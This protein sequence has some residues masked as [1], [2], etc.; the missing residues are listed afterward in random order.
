M[1]HN[2]KL[3][4]YFIILFI[5][6]FVLDGHAQ[7][8][9][10]PVLKSNL[11]IDE[12]KGTI[13][14]FP[15]FDLK[16]PEAKWEEDASYNAVFFKDE[17]VEGYY[18]IEAVDTEDNH[19]YRSWFP[20]AFSTLS[21]KGNRSYV[22]S[23]LMDA[24]FE[25]PDEVN[26]GLYT[27]DNAGNRI[28][29]HLNGI[30]NKTNGWKRWEWEII[31]DP[32]ATSARFEIRLENF[33][34]KN[35]LKISDIALVELPPKAIVPFEKGKGATFK[36]GPGNLPMKVASVNVE[37]GFIDVYIT[38]AQYTFDLKNNT[39]SGRQLV[40]T[41]R[42]VC[43]WKSTADLTGLKVLVENKK[44]CVLA[45]DYI[46]FGIQCDG[47]LMVVPHKEVRLDVESKIGGKWNRLSSGH[48]LAR[49][50]I[51][52]FAVNPDIPRGS[53]RFCR[54][55]AGTEP[56]RNT[57]GMIDF[58]G[59][60]DDQVFISKAD[61]GWQL[62]YYLSPGERLGISIF[63]PRPYPWKQS[64]HSK[65]TLTGTDTSLKSYKELG[66]YADITVL[67]DFTNRTWANSY[68]KNHT[69][70]DK[71][72]LRNHV[73]A[74]K[75]AG[76]K[77]IPYM[78]PYYYYSRDVDEFAEQLKIFRDEWG[79]E[80]AYFDAVPALEWLVAYEELRMT[81]EIYPDGF[82]LLHATGHPYDGGPPLGEPSIKIPAL[83]TYTDATYT[84]ENVYGYGKNW[85]YPKYITSQYN[86]SNCIGIMKYNG[87]DGLTPIQRDL[88]MLRHNGR[89]TMLP[90]GD[91]A[92]T[93]DS[94]LQE[95]NKIYF[96]ILRELEKLWDKKGYLPDFYENYYLPNAI[97][98]TKDFLPEGEVDPKGKNSYEGKQFL[99]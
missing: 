43:E 5:S 68:E 26:V 6:A 53:G 1:E 27:M 92:S 12:R 37:D 58:V 62:R 82:I 98:L 45:N 2:H 4:C 83:E 72:L 42:D 46:T 18:K 90:G 70:S 10:R 20:A 44:E 74:S 78:S 86:L 39:I 48:L 94:R 25:R 34:P 63:P 91:E 14:Q 77:P 15:N 59:K 79:M 7:L 31:T 60:V 19:N 95:M 97:E 17:N 30:A 28:Q 66:K 81:R 22:I 71:Q 21:I 3:I 47:M 93:N 33:P 65:F 38:A 87:W 69:V 16:K 55:D 40:G 75:K 99:H 76:I 9:I 80:G 35:V 56:G 13:L 36:G 41:E 61:P 50:E 85:T 57:K 23:I 24:D 64:F 8:S 67:W 96:P 49:D 32:R 51:G 88:M 89:A 54:I 11:K 84:G 52:G 29:S 73:R